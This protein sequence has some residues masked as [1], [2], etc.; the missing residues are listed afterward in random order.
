MVAMS[1]AG[2][3]DYDD[4][5]G[6][7]GEYEGER[8]EA[9][10]RHGAGKAVLPNGDTYQG[11][12]ESGKRCG[13]GTYRFKNG[14][15]YVG[16]YY[17]N[18]KHGQGTFYYPD[19]SRYEG[20]W[21]ED[22][23]HGQGEYTY[24]NGDTYDGEWLHHQRHGQGIYLYRDTGS[25]YV[26]TWVSGRMESA[27]EII[28]LNHKYQGNFVSNNPS[29][30]GKFVF[31]IGCEQHGEFTQ[32]DQDG[33][34]GEDEEP[35]STTFLKWRPLAIAGLTRLTPGKEQ[36]KLTSPD[37]AKGWM[38]P[39]L[40]DPEIQFAQRLASNEKTI[41]TKAIKKLRK[42]LSVRSQKP[43]GGFTLEELLKI[44]KG[45]FYC[46]WMQDKPLLQEE[47]STQISG[48]I[49]SL[50]NTDS[51]FLF[52]ESFLLTVNREWNGIDRLRMDKFYSLVR[53]VFRQAFEMMK[54]R[55]W[56]MSLGERFTELLSAQVL[57]STSEAPKGVQ[58]HVLDVYLTE[59]A[60]VGAAELTADQNL[61][62][63]SPFCKMAAKTKDHVLMQ[64]I[65]SSIF[66]EI[67]DQ[68]PFAIEDLMREVRHRGGAEGGADSD[69]ESESTSVPDKISKPKESRVNGVMAADEEEED[70]EEDDELLYLEEDSDAPL[71]EEGIGP[72][73]QFDFGA[74]ADRLFELASRT[75]TPSFN[76]T[77]LYKLVKTFRNLSEGVFPRDEAPEDVSTD[78]DDDMFGSRRRMRKRRRNREEEPELEG[79][80]AAKKCKAKKDE[81]KAADSEKNRVT[82][83]TEN[84]EA[85]S[86][87]S[88]A[89][90]KRRKKK[91]KKREEKKGAGDESEDRETQLTASAAQ[92]DTCTEQ[93]PRADDVERA[94]VGESQSLTSAEAQ[95]EAAAETAAD[96][97]PDSQSES[98][99]VGSTLREGKGKRR[100]R[101]P[102]TLEMNVVAADA[103]AAGAELIH[104]AAVEESQS[105]VEAEHVAP[106]EAEVTPPPPAASKK[107][108]RKK[109]SKEEKPMAEAA[110][111]CAVA[112]PAEP[113][114][115]DVVPAEPSC[116]DVSPAE[117]S[118]ADEQPADTPL[119]KR[120]R[121]KM[122]VA[123]QGGEGIEEVAQINGHTEERVPGGK[124]SKQGSLQENE[125]HVAEKRLKKKK[126]KAQA[127]A[128]SS[129]VT[130]QNPSVPAPLYCRQAKASPSTPLSRK[131]SSLTPL[132]ESKKV[133]FGLKNNQ[134]AEFRK[135]D[136][137][138]MVSP[139][140]SSRVPFDP[141]QKPRCSVLKSPAGRLATK[142]KSKSNGR[143][144]ASDFF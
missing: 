3:E 111:D 132:S 104:L 15:R 131:Q 20:S 25:R 48:L 42:Y 36:G 140:G 26:G 137:S 117:P 24:A 93:T 78:E 8:N 105:A 139:D 22:Q 115:A 97:Q 37:P 70:E 4:E 29:G 68:A 11:Q 125:L 65:C 28:H 7:L 130:F 124:K 77:R 44:W 66:Q 129:F 57:R 13:Q 122:K 58:L 14:A 60:R 54:R 74:V 27:G 138:L 75:N 120:K 32:V 103:D 63:I 49:H 86:A 53:F 112:S 21:V 108:N 106:D 142:S 69:Q 95:G 34:E 9:G 30:S 38:A 102:S 127:G 83:T 39:V 52:L 46:L 6:N 61:S 56:D 101:K 67:I 91:K 128:D 71:D 88:D 87:D 80:S 82:E 73:L 110:S 90:K 135:T 107:K 10:E 55:K 62:F 89:K 116:A 23:R 123:T 12:Y 118:C 136:R 85:P 64:A 51:Q 100:R 84:S 113:S 114:C 92:L 79:S 43:K 109:K 33:G 31:D 76:R 99:S 133:T 96:T 134:T 2:S 40:Q 5:Q 72:V 41:R 47:L 19:G 143:P 126:M 35:I 59:L 94:G 81:K 50:Q 18:K 121:K 16:E 1:D 119:K 141:S 144:R 98:A 45:L 17:M